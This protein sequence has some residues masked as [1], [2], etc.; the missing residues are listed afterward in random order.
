MRQ[1]VRHVRKGLVSDKTWVPF[2][3][4]LSEFAQ[5]P[6]RLLA[7]AYGFQLA[8][9]TL[10][11]NQD[12]LATDHNCDF[13]NETKFSRSYE[14]GLATG[15]WGYNTHLEWRVFVACWAAHRA[16][17]LNGDFVE[18]GVNRGG[19]ARAIIEYVDFGKSSKHFYL[20][21]TF[22]GLVEDQISARERELGR[23]PGGYSDCYE[24]VCETFGAFKN[25]VLVKGVVPD[26]LHLVKAEQVAYLSID[27]NCTQPEI[28]AGEYF[29][30]KL[31]PGA[32]ILLD[33]YSDFN[34]I[35]QKRAWDQFAFKHDTMVLNIPTGQGIIIKH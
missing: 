8:P 7:R 32:V 16:M 18:C 4:R 22:C 19:L 15:S 21:D 5:S 26:T 28:A 20:L 12:G 3:K 11:Y 34:F 25:V 2:R 17:R 24:A 27:M 29:W 33:D 1:Y 13:I 23:E 6:V 31:T 14:V 30:E 35:E 10:T 9:L